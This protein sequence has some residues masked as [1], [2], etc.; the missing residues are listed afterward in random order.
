ME[1]F[2]P[3]ADDNVLVDMS[4]SDDGGV[5]RLSPDLA[6][7]QSVDYITPIVDDPYE[8]GSIAAAN[9]LSDLYAMGARPVTV[10]NICNFPPKGIEPASLRRILDGAYGKIREAGAHLLG[11][12]SIRDNELKF[13]LSVTGVAHPDRIVRN[14]TA[15]PGDRLIL[16]KPLGTGVL[17]HAARKDRDAGPGL[18]AAIRSMSTLNRAAAEAML[19]VGVHAATDVT[20]FGL[21]GHAMEI[22]VGSGAD[23]V[24]ALKAIPLFD[25]VLELARDGVR[26]G[27]TGLNR[28]A[29]ADRTAVQGDPPAEHLDAV[30]DPQTS[31]GL[32]ISVAA[33]RADLLLDALEG[34]RVEGAAVIGAVVAGPG[35]I[36][37]DWSGGS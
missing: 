34:K 23:L 15:R 36:V 12:H 24:L 32:L 31:G 28:A 4:T 2:T 27:N 22:A 17:T 16:T 11:G 13:G 30:F 9:S 25:G 33:D 1:G 37:L 29:T 26:T 14:S 18:V 7:V 3:E 20:G 21:G 19:D 35:R 10:L 5:F 6:I 8:F